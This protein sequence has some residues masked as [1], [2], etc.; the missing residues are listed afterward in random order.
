MSKLF[1]LFNKHLSSDHYVLGTELGSNCQ[2][3]NALPS[4][5]PESLRRNSKENCN[6]NSVWYYREYGAVGNIEKVPKLFLGG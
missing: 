3:D 2:R 6:H 4:C 5:N 1:F